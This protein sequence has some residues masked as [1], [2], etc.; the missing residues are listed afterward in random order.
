MK[1][2]R[3]DSPERSARL[4]DRIRTLQPEAANLNLITIER[5]IAETQRRFPEARGNF[6]GLMNNIALAAKMISAHV[7]RAGLVD[8]LGETGEENVQGERVMKLDHYANET[9]IRVVGGGGHVCAMGSEENEEM[10]RVP[11][12]CEQGRYVLLFDPLDG[13]SNIDVNVSIGT[14]FSI[15]RRVTPDGGAADYPDLLQPGY[16]QVAA[17][18]VIYGSSTMFVYSAGMGVHGFTLDPSCGEFL[19]SHEDIRIPHRAPTYSVNEGYTNQWD[20]A[21]RAVV[22][23]FREGNEDRTPLSTR[24]IGSLVADFHRNLLQGGVFFYPA[25]AKEAGGESRPKLRLLYEAAPLAWIVEQAGGY[26]SDGFGPVLRRQPKHLHE[27]VPLIIGSQE[28]V[29]YA[30]RMLRMSTTDD[31]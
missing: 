14:I 20:D 11:H 7:N 31:A 17:G 24:Y 19:L 27:R 5:H 1:R 6:S 12:D 26:A 13:S 16:R 18:Y 8:I 9:L 28:D 4:V 3:G 2:S 29:R 30:E 15:L 23:V 25:G 10:I 22:R 21:T